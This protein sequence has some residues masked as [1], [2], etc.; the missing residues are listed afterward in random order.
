[1]EVFAARHPIFDAQ[2]EVY[3]YE[4]QFRQG[5][6][7]YYDQLESDTAAVDFMAFVNFGELVDG[8]V[9]LVPFTRNLVMKG[10]PALLPQESMITG[11]SAADGGDGPFLTALEKLSRKYG[12]RLAL[13]GATPQRLANG[14]VDLLDIVD[15]DFQQTDESQQQGV[16]ERIRDAKA[17]ALARNLTTAEEFEKALQLGYVYFQGD[18]FTKP[19]IK[20]GKKVSSEKINYVRLLNQVNSRDL[21]YDQIEEVIKQDVA[22]TYKLLQFMNSAWFGL[23]YEI[24]SVKHAL[25]MLGP[26]EIRRWVSVV[27]V[28]N[29]GD[30]KPREL[31]VRSLTRARV[32]ER[33]GTVAKVPGEASDLFLLG[34]F[35]LIDALTDLPMEQVLEDLPLDEQVKAALLGTGGQFA[36]VFDV[37]TSYESG[38]WDEFAYAARSL[39]L[40]EN[41]VPA[42]FRE[43]VTWAN[44]ALAEL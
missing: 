30:D 10:F 21:S 43:G 13:T 14:L 16:I 36:A 15:V 6:D 18:F 29:V 38:A 27:A 1:M 40:E 20:P 26:Q 24:H 25:V 5:F 33:L 3:G 37:I 34:M 41:A 2:Q 35:S 39:Q 42:L 28:R 8:K 11:V 32:A 19:V 23:R 4:L 31:L 22:L 7:E 12:Y 17:E 44:Q 9:G